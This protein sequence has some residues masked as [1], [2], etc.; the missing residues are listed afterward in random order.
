MIRRD[1]RLV[2]LWQDTENP[3]TGINKPD[4]SQRYD[5]IIVG[6]GI[7]GL[8]TALLLQE[9]GLKCMII[10]AATLGYGTTG[11]TTAHLNTLLDTSFPA[12]DKN[13][14]KQKSKLVAKAASEALQLVRDNCRRYQID[15]ELEDTDAFLFAQ[16]DEQVKDLHDIKESSIAAGLSIVSAP[17][18]P[19]AFTFKEAI[20]IHGQGKFHPIK[21]ILGLARAFDALGG[22]ILQ[23]CRVKGVEETEHA[24]VD[25]Q[26]GNFKTARVIYATHVP[27]GVN[28]LHL[29]CAPYRSYAMAVKLGDG[30]YP[31]E[32]FYDMY[33]PYHYYRTHVVGNEPYLIGGGFDHKSGHEANTEHCFLE[34]E[35][36]LRENF[37]VNSVAYRWSSLYFEP[38]DG[39][40]YIGRLPGHTDLVYAATGFG[41]NGMT[42]SHVA[43]MIFKSI[44]LNEKSDYV[45]LFNP[46]RIKPVAGFKNFITHNADVIK[47]FAGKFLS[48]EQI[49]SF[50]ELAPGEA[51]LVKL[52]G[53]KL[54][55]YKDE[56]GMLYAISPT[57]TH[58]GCEISWNTAEGSWDCPCHGARFSHEGEVLNAPASINLEQ[59]ELL[60]AGK[61]QV[62]Y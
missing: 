28:L 36:H 50:A 45:E 4:P 42:Y 10:E 16:T 56:K 1:G 17:E 61:N 39:L 14:G 30:K 26:N 22:V 58:L 57:C 25:T 31:R 44:L 2:S 27:P 8:S 5:A 47:Q 37:D 51:R 33:D 59:I 21:Y 38:A 41:G 13:F 15:C 48:H 3:Y 9:S 49:E 32:L 20:R 60:K 18:M 52:E 6:G 29:R 55:L 40:P 19:L 7:T 11:G 62:H 43:A 34:L 24:I 23:N 12:I 46:N 35:A 53:D 54:A